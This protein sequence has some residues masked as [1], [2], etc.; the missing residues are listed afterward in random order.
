MSKSQQALAIKFLT[1][2]VEALEHKS[3]LTTWETTLLSNA[4]DILKDE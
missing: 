3:K 2:L 1:E 4:K